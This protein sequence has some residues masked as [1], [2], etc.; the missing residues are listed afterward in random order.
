MSLPC[1]SCANTLD[2]FLFSRKI[3]LGSG[4]CFTCCCCATGCSVTYLTCGCMTVTV[5]FPFFF[6][7]V[8]LP[9]TQMGSACTTGPCLMDMLAQEQQWS[10]PNC[11]STISWNSCR[12]SWISWGT[13]LSSHPPAWERSLTTRPPT[14]GHWHGQPPCV[15]AWGPRAHPAHLQHVSSLRRRSHMSAWLLGL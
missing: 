3:P 10:L 5:S 2:Y 13:R 7:S 1:K 11:C 6:F 12:R 4:L 9:R 15:A 14:A 8:Y